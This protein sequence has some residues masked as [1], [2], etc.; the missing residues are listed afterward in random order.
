M[1]TKCDLELTRITC[2]SVYKS[3]EENLPDYRYTQDLHDLIDKIDREIAKYEAPPGISFFHAWFDGWFGY[4]WDANYRILYLGIPFFL[5]K[6][7]FR[8]ED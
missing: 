4:F 2:N 8:Q 6:I 1:L 7:Q 3:L 5:M